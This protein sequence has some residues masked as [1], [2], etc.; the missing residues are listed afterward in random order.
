MS[1]VSVIIPTYGMPQFLRKSIESVANQTYTDWELI[2]VDDNNPGTEA[3]IAT[4]KLIKSIAENDN[5]IRYIK[6]P[7]N[8]N[9]AAARNTGLAVARGKYIS[10]LDSDD[11]YMPERLAK[12]VKELDSKKED[13]A[14]VYTGC[15]F[16][17]GGKTYNR[18]TSVKS[19]NFLVETL[20]CR[21]MFCTGSNIFMRKSVIDKVNGFDESF[22]RHQDYEF[23][24]RIFKNYSLTAIPEILV[25]KNNENFNLPDIDKMEA[26][27]QQYLDKFSSII[28]NLSQRERK[29]VYYANYISLAEQSLTQHKRD[30]AN[31]F[32]QLASDCR[33]LTLRDSLR[34]YALIL[35]NYAKS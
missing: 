3:R 21:F 30:K 7:H 10:F 28:Q 2:I 23:L 25:I 12:C 11:E 31:K 33:S 27:K 20:A 15:E 4:E 1:M 9:G 18:F 19:G 29:Y 13:I 26:I 35:M 24:V 5:R 22:L 14:G 8:K 34:K 17:R 16:R 6:H 32:Y